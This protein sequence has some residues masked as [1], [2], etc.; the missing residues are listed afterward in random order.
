MSIGTYIQHL[1]AQVSTVAAFTRGGTTFVGLTVGAQNIDPTN[2][3][4]PRP[5]AW[6]VY[7]GDSV[8]DSTPMNPC[9]TTISRNFVVID[10]L[11]YTNDTDLVSGTQLELLDLVV[12]AVQGS[13][14]KVGSKWA[15]N[16]QAL[17]E[18]NADR[19]VWEQDYSVITTI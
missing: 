16:G 5:A 6:V 1:E 14:P 10:L 9:A 8:L 13:E 12:A 18:L 17:T 3:D 2:R 15:Y 11:D 7:I 4:L 19:M